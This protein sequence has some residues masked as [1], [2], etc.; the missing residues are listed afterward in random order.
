[1]G[2]RRV[3]DDGIALRGRT[4]HV[5]DVL[6]DDRRVWSFWSVRDSRRSWGVTRTIEWPR[7]L[8]PFLNGRTT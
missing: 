3:D 2:V 5:L 7:A 8:R 6:F 1:V 4:D